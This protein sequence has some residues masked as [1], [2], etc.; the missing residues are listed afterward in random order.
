MAA[1]SFT[2]EKQNLETYSLIWLDASVNSS[3]ENVEAQ[4]QLRTSINH[5]RIFEDDEQCENYIRSVP[6]EDRIVMIV[7]GPLGRQIVPR[8]H[9]LRQVF[10]ICVYCMNKEKHKEWAQEFSKVTSKSFSMF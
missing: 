9:Q 10:S 6:K 8:I 5:L 4:Q 1:V 3:Q 7:N 2:Q